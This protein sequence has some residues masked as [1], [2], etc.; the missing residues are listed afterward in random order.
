VTGTSTC[1]S[2][3]PRGHDQRGALVGLRPARQRVLA[4]PDASSSEPRPTLRKCPSHW[5]RFLRLSPRPNWRRAER[6]RAASDPR[7]PLS[8]R[9]R[10]LTSAIPTRARRTAASVPGTLETSSSHPLKSLQQPLL[11]SANQSGQRVTPSRR[12]DADVRVSVATSGRTAGV[13]ACVP[14]QKTGSPR[15]TYETDARRVG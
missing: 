6:G 14:H 3:R 1:S 11:D 7:L 9:L 8:Q 12:R 13:K 4:P 10:P 15:N 2:V 5:C